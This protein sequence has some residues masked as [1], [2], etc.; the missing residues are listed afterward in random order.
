MMCGPSCPTTSIQKAVVVMTGERSSLMVSPK[1]EEQLCVCWRGSGLHHHF[2]SLEQDREKLVI[3]CVD[4][5]QQTSVLLFPGF[6]P[7]MEGAVTFWTLCLLGG[8]LHLPRGTG[9]QVQRFCR[10]GSAPHLPK[11]DCTCVSRHQCCGG[12]CWGQRNQVSCEQ[13][14]WRQGQK[15]L[16]HQGQAEG[17]PAKIRRNGWERRGRIDGAGVDGGA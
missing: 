14:Q 11:S 4:G 17:G 9:W 7:K 16:C 13:S 5:G 1:K 12:F 10:C 6:G 2:L 8:A 15:G 3:A